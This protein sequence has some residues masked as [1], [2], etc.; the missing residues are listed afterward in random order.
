[1]IKFIEPV[2][3]TVIQNQIWNVIFYLETGISNW[4]IWNV[5]P[6]R[7]MVLFISDRYTVKF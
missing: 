5:D 6:T 4:Y 3:E 7:M 2:Y 1:M